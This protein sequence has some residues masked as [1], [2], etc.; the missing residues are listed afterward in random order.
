MDP[1]KKGLAYEIP[2]KDGTSAKNSQ[3]VAAEGNAVV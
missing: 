2:K 1:K 3:G